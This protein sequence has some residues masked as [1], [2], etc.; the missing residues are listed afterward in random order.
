MVL[1]KQKPCLIYKARLL[2]Y[3]FIC[4]FESAG[5]SPI[6]VIIVLTVSQ[7]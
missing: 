7:E 5:E 1:I 6:E 4:R 3:M 2:F